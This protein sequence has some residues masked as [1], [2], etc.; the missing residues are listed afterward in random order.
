MSRVVFVILDS[1]FVA[2]LAAQGH[3][4]GFAPT[5]K[6]GHI[7]HKQQ[8]SWH[9]IHRRF[10]RHSRSMFMAEEVRQD[11]T[12]KRYQ[13]RYPLW[14]IRKAMRLTA[15]LSVAM[16]S[17]DKSR[18]LRQSQPLTYHLG[19]LWQAWVLRRQK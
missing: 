12:T 17:F 11:E 2:R 16:L 14:R 5:A 10:F 13:F 7:V 15:C 8:T 9:W 3:A 6:V 4:V 18:I 19:A 1:D